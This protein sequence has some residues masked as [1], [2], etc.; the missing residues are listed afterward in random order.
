MHSKGEREMNIALRNKRPPDIDEAE[1]ADDERSS[2]SALL[3]ILPLL[4]F[5]DDDD[6][7][8]G[9]RVSVIMVGRGDH[10]MR[11]ARDYE[12]R[13]AQAVA[14]WNEWDNG[15]DE[16]GEAH[17]A[18]LG[19]LCDKYDLGSSALIDGTRFK[20]VEVEQPSLI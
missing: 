4:A 9:D 10:F 1:P 18:K 7:D 6:E 17:A 15:D 13:H 8:G 2:L 19:E 3:L 5:S 16:F 20:I 12:Q 14:E 11:R